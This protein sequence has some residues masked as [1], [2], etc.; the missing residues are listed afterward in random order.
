MD[1][2]KRTL[3]PI[4]QEAWTEI[5]AVARG[6][7][8][9]VLTARKV[10]DV[11]GPNGWDFSAV[12]LGRLDLPKKQPVPGVHFGLRTVLPLLEAR[13]PFELDI[14]EVDNIVRGA[15]D[16]DL[17][18]LED[19]ARALARFEEQAIYYGLS[20]ANI[21]GLKDSSDYKTISLTDNPDDIV[22]KVTLG[23]AQF[24]QHSI[25]GPYAMIVSPEL[26]LALAGHVKGYPLNQ[27]IE[28][29][30]QGPVMVSPYVQDA[31]LVTTRGGD[32]QLVLGQDIAIGYN[33]NDKEKVRLFFTESFTFYVSEPH[34]V[35]FFEW[36][37]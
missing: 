19:A 10:V 9:S 37:K 24:K 30:L 15:R 14:W 33:S 27:Y 1:I 2:L 18:P 3:A 25:D 26:W 4:T 32:M 5:D 8:T 22:E 17:H 34:A 6:A 28:N 20:Q 36:K 29:M 13:V 35:Q 16:A 31:F 12:T 21:K 7:L 11:E 23:L